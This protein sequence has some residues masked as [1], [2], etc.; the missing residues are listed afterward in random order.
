MQT[1]TNGW[2]RAGAAAYVAWGL[3]HIVV[4]L[5][6]V[7]RFLSDGPLAMLANLEGVSNVP[8]PPLGE[9]LLQ[10]SHLIGQHYFN[11]AAVG[12]MAILV[13]VGLNWNGDRLGY[14]L[15]LIVLGLVDLSFV[16]GEIIP[17]YMPLEIGGI[18]PALYLLGAA[19][20]TVGLRAGH[21]AAPSRPEHGG[22]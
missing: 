12:V 14:W 22:G 9:P 3:L 6:P 7:V 21:Q 20:T 1:D 4:G 11:L 18:G 2:N 8:S 16:V 15:N 13:A 5:L 19:L 10:A 17:G